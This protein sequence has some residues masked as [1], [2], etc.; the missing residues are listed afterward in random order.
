MDL[1]RDG[2]FCLWGVVGWGG[3]LKGDSDLCDSE[4][5]FLSSLGN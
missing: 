5:V 2:R 4:E 1:D 3:S